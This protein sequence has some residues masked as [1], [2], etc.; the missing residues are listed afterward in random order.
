[1]WNSPLG[2][3]P[4]KTRGL[5]C[6]GALIQTRG[7]AERE[8]GESRTSRAACRRPS[9]HPLARPL[10]RRRAGRGD[11]GEGHRL[12]LRRRTLAGRAR[13]RVGASATIWEV[14]AATTQY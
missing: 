4:E 3:I 8:L 7:I 2:W 10:G 9:A 14:D 1:M 11:R 6:V 12:A 13:E 5:A